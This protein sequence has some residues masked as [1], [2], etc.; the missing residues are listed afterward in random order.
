M[1]IY[2]NRILKYL[3]GEMSPLERDAFREELKKNADMLKE[4][5]F[6]LMAEDLLVGEP[7]LEEIMKDPGMKQVEEDAKMIADAWITAQDK[8]DAMRDKAG[9]E[10]LQPGAG[11]DP[12]KTREKR[13]SRSGTNWMLI[14]ILLGQPLAAFIIMALVIKIFILPPRAEDFF[15]STVPEMTPAEMIPQDMPADLRNTLGTGLDYY[16]A[17]NYESALQIFQTLEPHWKDYPVIRLYMGLA[18]MRSGDNRAALKNFWKIQSVEG[19]HLEYA[20]F[21]SGLCYVRLGN[22]RAAALYLTELS[23]LSKR[24][25]PSTQKLLR[26]V[27]LI[28]TFQFK[29]LKKELAAD[30]PSGKAIGP[31]QTMILLTTVIL[32]TLVWLLP[33]IDIINR[34]YPRKKTNFWLAM[35]F[36]F[37]IPGTLAYLI[38]GRRKH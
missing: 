26:R 34:K 5:R 32:M 3:E 31:M 8:R 33:A 2:T 37:N 29:L 20:S 6:V 38:F 10:A 30:E 9:D 18:E 15:Q 22:P 13:K 23:G 21:F 16:N 11:S 36:L 4:F 27:N 24:L 28:N 14:P 1:S 35:V 17:G 7:L 12:Y 25:D 19:P